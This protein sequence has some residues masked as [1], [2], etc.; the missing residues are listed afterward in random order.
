[1]GSETNFQS[2]TQLCKTLESTSKRNEKKQLIASFLRTLQPKEVKPGIAFLTARALPPNEANALEVGGRTLS[3]ILS[4]SKQATLTPSAFSIS[5]VAEYFS[6]ISSAQGK[7]SRTI[8]ESLLRALLS[9]ATQEERKYLLGILTGELRIGAVEG[10]V[11]EAVA[12]AGNAPVPLVRRASLIIGDI[13]EVAEQLL[14][15]GQEA[16]KTVKIQLFRPIKPMLAEMSYDLDEVFREHGGTTAFEYKFDGA[17]IQIHKKDRAV[18]IYSR[19]LS[20]VT[21][22]IPDIVETVLGS[23]HSDDVLVEGEAVAQGKD[24]KPL[25][26]QDLM[27]RFT[28]VHNIG[29]LVKAV[30]L[31]LYLFDILHLDGEMLIDTPYNQRWKVLESTCDSEVVAPRI[32]T[33]SR[34]TAEEFLVVA[35]KAGHEGLMAKAL[36]SDYS[37]GTRGKK[38]FKIKPFERLDLVIVAADWGYGRR[39]GWLSNYHLAARDEETGG[40]AMLG[41]TFKGLTDIE[42]RDMTQ[43]LQGFKVSEDEYTIYVKPTV[44][45]EVG[46][47]EIQHSPHY[48]SGFALRFARITRIREDKSPEDADTLERV[49]RLYEKQFEA[50]ARINL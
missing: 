24:G 16:L 31:K 14:T 46:Y 25:P 19:A 43:R 4:E 21:G 22:S 11:L 35:L 44:V 42:F 17:R 2:F 26:F 5:K 28:R 3:R 39:R 12:E 30:P 10:V 15:T 41:K 37:P 48:K 9:Q 18:K 45:V 32:V 49:R 38:W 47:N 33:G 6:Q 36:T 50:K 1:M 20:E 27:R 40:Y 34:K 7:G 13:G 23:V 8:K 29:Q